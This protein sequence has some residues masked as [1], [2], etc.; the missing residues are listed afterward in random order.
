MKELDDDE[1]V[2]NL[3]KGGRPIEIDEPQVHKTVN[4]TERQLRWLQ[5]QTMTGNIS[6]VLRELINDAIVRQHMKGKRK[7]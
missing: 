7:K 6:A 1:W 3:H 5:K 4:L 2:Q